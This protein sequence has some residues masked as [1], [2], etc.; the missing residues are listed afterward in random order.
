MTA[1]YIV[2]KLIAPLNNYIRLRYNEKWL[3]MLLKLKRH[4]NLIKIVRNFK[5]YIHWIDNISSKPKT[6]LIKN[7]YIFLFSSLKTLMS[8]N[9]I[10]Y[11]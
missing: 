9:K 1:I 2:I 7:L 8:R 11:I 4:L 3:L 10:S 6:H 5:D